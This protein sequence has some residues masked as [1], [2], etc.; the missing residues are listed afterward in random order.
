[1]GDKFIDFTSGIQ[2][3]FIPASFCAPCETTL[4]VWLEDNDLNKVSTQIRAGDVVSVMPTSK[5]LSTDARERL[6]ASMHSRFGIE[7]VPRGLLLTVVRGEETIIIKSL[8]FRHHLPPD[9]FQLEVY[10]GSLVYL[11]ESD[12]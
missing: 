3:F 2:R 1:M 5:P 9:E 4:V 10:N 6:A 12:D 7:T 11:H 8:R